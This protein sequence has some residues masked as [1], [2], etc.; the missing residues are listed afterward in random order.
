M[1]V[2]YAATGIPGEEPVMQTIAHRAQLPRRSGLETT[3]AFA[4]FR[5]ARSGASTKHA[6]STATPVQPAATF[7]PYVGWSG[8]RVKIVR[9]ARSNGG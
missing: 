4:I 8:G 6:A 9:A 2:D 1:D 5:L 7:Q 3:I